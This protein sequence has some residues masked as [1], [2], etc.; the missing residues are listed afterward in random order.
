METK[1][2]ATAKIHWLDSDHGGRKSLPSGSIYAATARFADQE[3]G[4]FSVVLRFPQKK[5]SHRQSPSG[6]LG[7]LLSNQVEAK[8]APRSL[9]EAEIGF[10]A[11]EIVEKKLVPGVKLLI[12]EGPHIVAECEIQSVLCSNMGISANF[13]SCP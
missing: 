5:A 12:T 4:F 13:N 11:P 1:L 6:T 7:F 10:L 2:L 8:P 3:G 9:D